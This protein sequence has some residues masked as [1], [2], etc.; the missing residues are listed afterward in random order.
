VHAGERV[1]A[2]RTVPDRARSV[3]DGGG[4]PTTGPGPAR[5]RANVEPL[6]LADRRGRMPPS[7]SG[8]GSSSRSATQPTAS[9]G[10]PARNSRPRGGA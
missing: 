10:G 2:E 6:D 1:E 8:A 5:D 9:S 4:E 3:D 7:A